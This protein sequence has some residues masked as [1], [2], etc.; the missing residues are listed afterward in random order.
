M[1]ARTVTPPVIICSA[2]VAI[3][4][5]SPWAFWM[6]YSTPASSKASSSSGRSAVSQRAED[7]VSGRMTP[8]LPAASPPPPP[9]LSP[10]SPPQAVSP[11]T[12]ATEIAV[13]RVLRR[14]MRADLPFVGDASEFGRIILSRS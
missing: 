13:V 11:R 10:S 12:T 5:A 1:I 3:R 4:W 14:A 2:M 8:T 6:S 7:A 9:P